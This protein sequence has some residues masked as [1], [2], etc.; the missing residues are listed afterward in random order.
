MR[1]TVAETYYYDNE[2]NCFQLSDLYKRIG[3]AGLDSS[4][5][6]FCRGREI[7]SHYGVYFFEEKPDDF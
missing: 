1:K 6:E 3:E 5:N 4:Y 7:K 2:G